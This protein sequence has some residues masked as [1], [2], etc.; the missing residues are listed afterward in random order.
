MSINQFA[1]DPLLLLYSIN[2]CRLEAN[3]YNQSN[4]SP[5]SVIICFHEEAVSALFRTVYSVLDRSPEHLIH[6]IILIDDYSS[7]RK[8]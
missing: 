8:Y 5:A 7:Q 1:V 4:L 6:E 2:S 3:Y